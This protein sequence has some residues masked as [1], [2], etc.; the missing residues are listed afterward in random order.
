MVD[1]LQTILAW[2]VFLSMLWLDLCI[3][4][5]LI[6][7]LEVILP[8]INLDIKFSQQIKKQSNYK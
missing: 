2:G 6:Y 5:V 3:V 7:A 4:M 8:P 1:V